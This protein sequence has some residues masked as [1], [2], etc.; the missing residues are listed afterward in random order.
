MDVYCEYCQKISN[1]SHTFVGNKIVD[2]SDVVGALP[3]SAVQ[4]TSSFSTLQWT[5]QRQLQDKT[6]NIEVLGFGVSYII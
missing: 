4:T 3:V 2:H 6:R 1:I 5:G